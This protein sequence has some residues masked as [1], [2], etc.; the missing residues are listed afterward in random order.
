MGIQGIISADQR[1]LEENMGSQVIASCGCGVKAEISIGGGMMD[2]TTICLFP[3]LC[4]SCRNVVET[5]LL[6]KTPECP[7]CGTANPTPYDDP[8]VVGSP[9][10]NI[11]SEWNVEEHLGRELTLTDGSY[12]CPKCEK[13]TLRF[14]DTGV[15]FN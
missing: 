13:M 6:S 1:C 15:F 10:E 3:C 14:T 4:N 2:F 8:R 7:G 9:G 11:V 12:K 5:N